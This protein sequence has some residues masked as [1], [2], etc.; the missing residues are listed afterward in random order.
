ME[1]YNA[2]IDIGV[3]VEEK[4][5]SKLLSRKSTGIKRRRNRSYSDATSPFEVAAKSDVAMTDTTDINKVPTS[6][7]K[8][9]SSGY[10]DRYNGQLSTGTKTKRKKKKKKKDDFSDIVGKASPNNSH[11]EDKEKN[12]KKIPPLAPLKGMFIKER[13][14]LPVYQHRD[15]ICKLVLNNDVVLVVAETVSAFLQFNFGKFHCFNHAYFR[16]ISAM[17]FGN[18]WNDSFFDH[19]CIPITINIPGNVHY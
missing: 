6:Q 7:N 10:K 14:N 3:A 16:L 2:S 11:L 8:A 5:S 15:E 19:L 4:P 9:S 17:I 12:E 18:H 1:E 13:S